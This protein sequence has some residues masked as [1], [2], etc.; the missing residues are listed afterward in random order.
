MTVTRAFDAAH[1][2]AESE[3]RYRLVAEN[4]SDVVYLAGPDRKVRWIAPSVTRTLGWEPAEIIGTEAIDLVHPDDRARHPGAPRGGHLRGASGA[5]PR[6][7]AYGLLLRVRRKSGDYRWIVGFEHPAVRRGRRAHRRRRLDARR[8]RSRAGPRGG[9]GRAGPPRGD[10]RTR[11]STRTCSSRPSATWTAASS[12]SS[13]GR[14]TRRPASTCSCPHERAGGRHGLLDLLPG[15]AGSGMLALYADA[16][17]TGTSARPRRLRVPARDPARGSRRFDIRAIR[18]NDGLSFT[19]RDVT[20]R[21]RRTATARRERGA[22][23]AAGGQLDR[24]DRRSCATGSFA[25]VSTSMRAML[26]WDPDDLV[27]RPS[28]DFI[29]PDDHARVLAGRVMLKAGPHGSAPIPTPGQG[30][31]LPLGRRAGRSDVPATT[32]HSTAASCRSGSS[33][34]RCGRRRRSSSGPGRTS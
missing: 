34:P 25:W 33:T 18:V 17:D 26:G 2:L 11:C 12:T 20:D 13:T 30:R 9:T 21:Y 6:R 14:P 23:S 19:W 5:R 32:A 4:S 24:R 15:Q 28:L 8:R 27:G 16:V 10:R 1:A 29:H 3:E 22:L 31:P 7:A